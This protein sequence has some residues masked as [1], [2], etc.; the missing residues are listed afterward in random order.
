MGQPKQLLPLGDRPVLRHC[1]DT[2]NRAW[3][4]EIVVVCGADVK[5]YETALA[6]SGARLVPNER[7]GSE[8]ADS[9]R[10]ALGQIATAAYSAILVCLADHP[11][12][13][14]A[15]C[16]ALID[17]HRRS[18]D[19]I[20]V[21]SFRER[22]GHP[23]LF[24]TEIISDIFSKPCL[25]DIVHEDPARVLTIAVDDQGVVLDMDTRPDYQKALAL[26]QARTETIRNA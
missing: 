11:L 22:R 1:I 14:P 10:L 4:N 7:E 23:T 3:V 18:P 2:L 24:P 9:V 6:D 13:R 15:T 17:R 19:K 20:V 26:Y 8:M 25:R 5:S 21:P 12:V 16:V